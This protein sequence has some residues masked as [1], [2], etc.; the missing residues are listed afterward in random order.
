MLQGSRSPIG[1][2][3]I[4]LRLVVMTIFDDND[5]CVIEKINTAGRKKRSI[6]NNC[7]FLFFTTKGFVFTSP[8]A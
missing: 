3:Q 5:L 7:S 8:Q 1:L 2:D 4:R 6:S